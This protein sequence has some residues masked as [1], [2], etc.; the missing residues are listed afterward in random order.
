VKAEIARRLASIGPASRRRWG[1]M[2]AGQMICHLSDAFRAVYSLPL[3]LNSPGIP[4]DQIRTYLDKCPS[5]AIVGIDGVIDPRE[6]NEMSAGQV[7]RNIPF[8]AEVPTEHAQTKFYIDVIPYYLVIGLL[9]AGHLLWDA[10]PPDRVADNEDVSLRYERALYPL[11]HAQSLIAR[12]RGTPRLAGWYALRDPE[13]E[14]VRSVFVREGAMT[15]L[16][17]LSNRA[18]IHDVQID[19]KVLTVRASQA[20]VAVAP[21]EGVL[22]VATPF[23]LLDLKGTRVAS[24]ENGRYVGD[25][26]HPIGPHP[27][28]ASPNG[29]R[30]NVSEPSVLRIQF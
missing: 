18:Y 9:G 16:E 12:H 29:S 8:A 20:G 5:I 23:A 21:S 4:P 19:G 11:K 27:F 10:L 6:P 25:T 1:A 2:T 13:S 14:S 15:R 24:V 17:S 3:Y 26:W 30:I 22:V 28:E 7:G